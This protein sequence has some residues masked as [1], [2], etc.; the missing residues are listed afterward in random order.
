MASMQEM[1]AEIARLKQELERKEAAE[2]ELAKIHASL[3]LPG[4][5]V[6]LVF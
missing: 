4:L 3:T 5:F 2:Q 1:Q 6:C